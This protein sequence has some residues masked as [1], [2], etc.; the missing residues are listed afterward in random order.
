M[1]IFFICSSLEPGRDGAGDQAR[2]LAAQLTKSGHEVILASLNELNISDRITGHQDSENVSLI[3]DR[4][5]ASWPAGAKLKIIRS[6]V[7]KFCPDWVSLQFVNFGYHRYGLPWKLI[8]PLRDAI[9]QSHLNIMFQELW[10]GIGPKPG[11]KERILGATQMIFLK[12]MLLRLKP[13]AVFTNN[14]QYLSMLKRLGVTAKLAPVF[15][16]IP[17]SEFGNDKEWEDIKNRVSLNDI[18]T[19]TE[20]SLVVGFFGTVYPAEDLELLLANA[21]EAAKILGR[22]LIILIIGHGRGVDVKPLVE[23]FTDSLY[24]K[25][26]ELSPEMINRAMQLVDIGIIT[27]PASV[28]NKSSTGSAWLERGI[29]LL[30]PNSD[31][32]Y[33]K[34]TLINRGI[35]QSGS[36][37][38]VI[39]CFNAKGNFKPKNRFKEIVDTYEGLNETAVHNQVEIAGR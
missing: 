9:G 12:I 2:S 37:E 11:I 6:T 10:C 26:G 25:L 34:S 1:K 32:T 7:K 29:P 14:N 36:P 22:K 17:L 19:Q 38:D 23:N 13:G 30:L 39:A 35:Y 27:T 3:V 31:N 33:N 21:H 5:P 15:G 20:K 4:L 8:M 24:F 18:D 28:L 16:N